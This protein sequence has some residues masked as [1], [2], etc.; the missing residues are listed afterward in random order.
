MQTNQSAR[1]TGRHIIDSGALSTND[2]AFAPHEY[3][4]AQKQGSGIRGVGASHIKPMSAKVL[5]LRS[6]PMDCVIAGDTNYAPFE[7]RRDSG[8][9]YKMRENA[10]TAAANAIEQGM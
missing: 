4:T 7:G 1:F 3:V 2:S 5:H 8:L 9:Q 6:V 10:R